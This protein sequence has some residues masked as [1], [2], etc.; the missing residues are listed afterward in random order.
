M[1]PKIVSALKRGLSAIFFPPGYVVLSAFTYL[2]FW[3]LWR[4]VVGEKP[5]PE[6][7]TSVYLAVIVGVSLTDLLKRSRWLGMK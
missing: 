1:L 4:D 3:L 2:F 7:F 5:Y 6:Y